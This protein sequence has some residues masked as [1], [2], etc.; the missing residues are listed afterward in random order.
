MAVA[1]EANKRHALKMIAAAD[2]G[3]AFDVLA[4]VMK[5]ASA[6]GQRRLAGELATDAVGVATLISLVEEGKAGAGLLKLP[7]IAQNLSAVTN[8]AQKKKIEGLVSELPSASERLDE[9]MEKR[10]Q[11]YI[12]NSGKV[13][14]GREIFQKICSACH[15]VGAEGRE[16][17]PNLDG[18]GNRGLDRL[19][20]DILDP[21]RNVD[22][23]FRSTTIVTRKGQVYSGLLRPGDGKRVVLVDSQGKEVSVPQASVARRAPS[24]LSPMPA[25]F[26][27]TLGE[28]QFRDLLSYL[29]SLRSS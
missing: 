16:F 17:A 22:V 5:A 26:S 20:E 12:D 10:K 15:K 19:I 24:R 21:N 25:N 7:S 29:L 14:P 3:G 8:G 4:S 13:G 28:E 27:E 11:S 23:A 1:S 6:P 2:A 18:A 9:I